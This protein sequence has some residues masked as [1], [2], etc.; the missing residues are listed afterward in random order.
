MAFKETLMAFFKLQSWVFTFCALSINK[1]ENEKGCK[2]CKGK[3]ALG[4]W[5]MRLLSFNPNS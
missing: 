3:R 4:Y 5:H 1:K 2:K